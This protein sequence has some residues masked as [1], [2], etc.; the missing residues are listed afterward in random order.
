MV[1]VVVVVAVAVG[2]VG[3]VVRKKDEQLDNALSNVGWSE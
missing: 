3:V 2:V 1:V